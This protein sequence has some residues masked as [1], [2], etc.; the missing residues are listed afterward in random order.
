[1][2]HYFFEQV[3]LK[4]MQLILRLLLACLIFSKTFGQSNFSSGYNTVKEKPVS[5]YY[6]SMNDKSDFQKYKIRNL[7]D[8]MNNY[9]GRLHDLQRRFDEIF[10][11]LSTK[12]IH[13]KPFDLSEKPADQNS[14]RTYWY[15]SNL[16]TYDQRLQEARTR[17]QRLT[18]PPR[19]EKK[20]SVPTVIV[21]VSEEGSSAIPNS[22]MDTSEQLY[23]GYLILHPGVSFPFKVQN[24][25][26][27]VGESER[28]YVPGPSLALSAG[29]DYET[30]NF[31]LGFQYKRNSL[32]QKSF[33]NYGT[34]TETI[35][36]KSQ[37][38]AAYF[39]VGFKTEITQDL[40]AYF[41][42][43][44]G[45]FRTTFQSLNKESDKGLYGTGALGLEWSLSEAMKFRLGY[46]YAHEDEVPSHICEA[47][48]NFLY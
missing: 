46:R 7:K 29:F 25:N 44:L 18:L 32:S 47:G 31:G 37:T 2:L 24:E 22:E 11:G 8:E 41:G 38:L 27:S 12:G 34:S 26:P 4:K 33:Y 40:D 16:T 9:S 28:E 17:P 45:Y 1:M 30:F 43:G 36:G 19:I 13:R 14:R 48:L 5:D 39:D 10:Y 42:L 23:G 6:S 3:A 21:P 35:S 15:D 20:E